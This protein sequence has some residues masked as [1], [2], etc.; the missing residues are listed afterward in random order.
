LE[1]FRLRAH[2]G[3]V[4]AEFFAIA[5]AKGKVRVLARV[6][7]AMW[8]QNKSIPRDVDSYLRA[9]A[10]CASSAVLAIFEAMVVW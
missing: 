1:E 5:A 7:Q 4:N 9:P 10:T 6:E 8:S 2:D 3:F